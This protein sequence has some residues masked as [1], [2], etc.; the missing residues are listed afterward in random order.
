MRVTNVVLL[1]RHSSREKKS[2]LNSRMTRHKKHR[3]KEVFDFIE[4]NMLF[5]KSHISPE[6]H[7]NLRRH[8]SVFI[9]FNEKKNKTTDNVRKCLYRI[10]IDPMKD[11]HL[12]IWILYNRIQERKN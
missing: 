4:A 11:F 1:I 12:Y 9:D 6:R 8:K 10:L 2:K 7:V 5:E 3:F